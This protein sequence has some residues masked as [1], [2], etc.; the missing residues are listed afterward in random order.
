MDIKI[1]VL[2][3]NTACSEDLGHAHG[4]S[5]YIETE[6][7]HILFD[8]GPDGKLLLANAEALG[9]DLKKVDTA[10]LSHGHYDHAGGLSAFLE[11]NESAKLY[12]HRLAPA[13]HYAAESVGF[14]Y[15]GLAPDIT[16]KYSGRIA[17][18]DDVFSIDDELTLFSDIK[19]A[20]FLSGSNT[21]L[22]E[23]NEGAYEY[24]RFLHEQDLLICRGSGPCL[25]PAAP[26]GAS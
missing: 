24:D 3:E 6:K 14:R 11:I 19:T 10:I 15:I 7:H 1:T 17:F 9:I 23:E 8:A 12:M 16:E 5:L 13:G 2:V 25:W 21:S 22:F 26:T 20:D 4:L 18:T